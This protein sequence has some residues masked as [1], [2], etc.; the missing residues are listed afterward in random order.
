LTPTPNRSKDESTGVP[1][2]AASLAPIQKFP[3]SSRSCAWAGAFAC[4]ERRASRFL[5]LIERPSFLLPRHAPLPVARARLP[6]GSCASCAKSVLSL[7][8]FYAFWRVP[9]KSLLRC[10]LLAA[11]AATPAINLAGA[12]QPPAPANVTAIRAGR[13]INVR[14]GQVRQN[15]V[16][17]IE[18]DRI[19]R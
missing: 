9:V 5:P 12:Q 11:F 2:P 15:A 4:L 17:V 7:R 16:I 1:L 18:K 13:L 19:S 8:R 6:M 3:R 10:A 14:T